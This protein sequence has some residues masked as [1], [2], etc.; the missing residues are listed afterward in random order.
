VCANIKSRLSARV[1]EHALLRGSASAADK[2]TALVLASQ[3]AHNFCQGAKCVWQLPAALSEGIVIVS[4]VINASGPLSGGIAA[5]LLIAGFLALF[6]M[7]LKMASLKRELNIEQDKQV[8]LFYEVLANIRSFRF[9]GWDLFFLNKLNILTDAL[10]PIQNKILVLKALNVTTVVCFP[11]VCSLIVFIV[12]YYET[13]S[14][15]STT[16]QATCPY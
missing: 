12:R 9:Y 16:F 2:S 4:L 3:D 1:A 10:I 5:G 6:A 13:G 11:C 15:S 14:F 7:L 8:S